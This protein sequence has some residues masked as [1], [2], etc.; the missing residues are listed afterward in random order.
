MSKYTTELRFICEE[1]AGLTESADY[2]SVSTIIEQARPKIFNFDYPIFDTDY[3][4]TLETKILKNY[5]TREISAE[6]YGLWHLWLDN[7]MN[8][9]MPYYNQLYESELLEFNPLQDT[10][11]TTDSD[12]SREGNSTDTGTTTET[13]NK[14]TTDNTDREQTVAETGTETNV[15]DHDETGT[16]T[17]NKLQWDLYNDTPQGGVTGIE[18]LNYLTNARKI[19]NND[20]NNYGK[21]IDVTDTL[22]KNLNTHTDEDIARSVVEA[23]TRNGSNNG[24]NNFTNTED[25]LKHVIGKSGGVSYSKLLEEYRKTFLNIDAKIIK[26]LSTLFFNIW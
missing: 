16:S 9:I 20:T 15:K 21:N 14:N 17:D 22:T 3:K 10:N 24:T 7:K 11:I 6:T 23:L 13:V 12:T 25:Y 26:E 5:Y 4:A 18:E 8:I 1:L 2:T 19:T